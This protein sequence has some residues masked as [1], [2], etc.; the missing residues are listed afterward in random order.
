MTYEIIVKRKTGEHVQEVSRYG[1][2]VGQ[3]RLGRGSKTDLE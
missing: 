3:G 1:E 2:G